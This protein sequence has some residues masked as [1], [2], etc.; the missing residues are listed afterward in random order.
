MENLSELTELLA[1]DNS[2]YHHGYSTIELRNLLN[3]KTIPSF[4]DRRLLS[5]TLVQIL[6]IAKDGLSQRGY[7]EDTF[8][9]PL[10]V[11]A[12]NL[13]NPARELTNGLD[14]G[15]SIEHYIKKYAT[16]KPRKEVLKHG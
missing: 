1:Q 2:L 5:N 15:Y 6:D 9:E 7:Y 8:L 14:S 3:L 12:E 10:Y 16:V 4:I 11:R 13:T